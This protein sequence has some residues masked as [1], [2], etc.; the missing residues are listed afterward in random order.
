MDVS[1]AYDYLANRPY[2]QLSKVTSACGFSTKLDWSA[3][4][5]NVERELLEI[6]SNIVVSRRINPYSPNT[7]LTAFVSTHPLSSSNQMNIVL[8]QNLTRAQAVCS[9][10]NSSLFFAQ[11]L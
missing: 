6:R 11:F 2:K 9:L 1:R 8:E 10:L 4:W 5:K 3:F 7:H